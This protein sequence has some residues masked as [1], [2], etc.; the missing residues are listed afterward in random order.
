MFHARLASLHEQDL[1]SDERLQTSEKLISKS[2]AQAKSPKQFI[3]DL[4]NDPTYSKEFKN[5][6]KILQFFAQEANAHKGDEEF[7]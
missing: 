3:Q 2:D 4:E 7:L 1:I 6:I 5:N